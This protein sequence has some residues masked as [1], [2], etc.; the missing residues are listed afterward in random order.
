M[1][2]LVSSP[3][4]S[5]RDVDQDYRCNPAKGERRDR[6]TLVAVKQLRSTK[7]DEGR[8]RQDEEDGLVR[9]SAV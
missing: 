2:P 9:Y 3:R 5:W 8:V 6:Q 1:L 4:D 7:D